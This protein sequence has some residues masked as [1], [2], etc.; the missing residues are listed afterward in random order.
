MIIECIWCSMFKGICFFYFFQGFTNWSKRDFNQFIKA[1]EKYG[2]DDIDSIC[3]EVEGKTPEEVRPIYH[4]YTCL[5]R[6]H[7]MMW[8]SFKH[9]ILTTW[10][11]DT[12][13]PKPSRR[14]THTS[15]VHPRPYFRVYISCIKSLVINT[16]MLINVLLYG[17]GGL[18]FIRMTDQSRVFHAS[19]TSDM[20]QWGF[21][22]S[23]RERMAGLRSSSY[24]LS[25][26]KYV[27]FIDLYWIKKDWNLIIFVFIHSMTIPIT[28]Y[29]L[30][31][32]AVLA[33][34]IISWTVTQICYKFSSAHTWN[35]WF[36]HR[37]SKYCQNLM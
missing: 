10:E 13:N 24:T 7:I 27:H 29:L 37:E 21:L 14:G 15:N 22:R 2:R 5:K 28:Q 16:Y 3:R 4:V 9:Y 1:N 8:D 6:T 19:S 25:S 11:A 18:W 31:K 36:L 35:I 32:S 20:K 33:S 17:E 26:W 30:S 34:F 12:L 23:A